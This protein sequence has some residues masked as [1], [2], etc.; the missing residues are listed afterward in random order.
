MHTVRIDDVPKQCAELYNGENEIG[1]DS[2]H[3][4]HLFFL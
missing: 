3:M 2:R 1:P 4:C